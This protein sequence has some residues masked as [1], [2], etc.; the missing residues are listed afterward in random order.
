[1][2]CYLMWHVLT[3]QHDEI[4]MSFLLV[5]HT[6]FSPD[7]GFGML[8]SKFR[9]TNVGC[10]LDIASIINKSAAMNHTQLMG[11]QSGN[12]MVETYV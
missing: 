9:L 4:T 7:A 11:D 3:G 2:M 12:V 10:L 1:M 5:G 8:K 6:K